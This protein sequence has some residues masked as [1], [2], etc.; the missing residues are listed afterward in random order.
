VKR[1]TAAVLL[2]ALAGAACGD[3]EPSVLREHGACR[4]AVRVMAE[5]DPDVTA[6]KIRKDLADL[7][8]DEGLVDLCVAIANDLCS[9]VT[10]TTLSECP[11]A[12]TASTTHPRLE[13]A[14]SAH[15]A[16]M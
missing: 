8:S 9:G 2:L 16:A 6:D 12:G 10:R 11:G 15:I 13:A 14:R 1:G 7:A 5:A 3:S 4:L